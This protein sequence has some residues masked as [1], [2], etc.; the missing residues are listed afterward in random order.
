MLKVRVWVLVVVALLCIKTRDRGEDSRHVF[1]RRLLFILES[2]LTG[3]HLFVLLYVV[4]S[5]REFALL[6]LLCEL[7]CV[8]VYVARE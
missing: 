1:Y 7:V 4:V 6:F 3:A 8:C 2:W 5:G